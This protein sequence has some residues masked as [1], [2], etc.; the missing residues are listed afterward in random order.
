MNRKTSG[1]G[2][3][4]QTS[5]SNTERQA[6][7][8][9]KSTS[10]SEIPTT[11]TEVPTSNTEIL[12]TT[13]IIQNKPHI[14]KTIRIAPATSNFKLMTGWLSNRPKENQSKLNIS[15][16]IDCTEMNSKQ[17]NAIARTKQIQQQGT[18]METSASVLASAISTSM[19]I[20]KTTTTQIDTNRH[21]TTSVSNSKPCRIS[22]IKEMTKPTTITTTIKHIE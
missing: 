22:R 11:S 9:E 18:S 14:T 2:A 13:R 10:T 8:T 21:T 3:G 17:I 20:T 12:E 5:T 15:S 6:S 4:T 16:E 19:K 7:C 1:T